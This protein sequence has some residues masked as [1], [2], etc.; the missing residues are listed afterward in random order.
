MDSGIFYSFLL[1]L[2]L[3]ANTLSALAGGGA[4]LVQLPALI[5][6]GLPFGIALATHKIATVALGVG[7]ALRY[8][9]EGLIDHKL[10]MVVLLFGLP[11]VVLGSVVI[12]NIN[13][14]LSTFTLGLLTLLLSLYSITNKQLGEKLSK[15]NTDTKGLIKGGLIIFV[16]GVANGSLSSGTGLFATLWFI[17]WFGLDYKRAV[18]LTML[19][20]GLFWNGTG[21]ITLSIIGEVRWDWLIPLIFGAV[22]GGYLGANIAVMKGNRF[23]KRCF[24]CL[25]CVVGVSLMTKVVLSI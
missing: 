23:I 22:A 16:I 12:L 14:L 18:A 10:V 17:Y 2:S 1:L 3:V 5:L 11:G 4:G 6:L 7:S 19:L 15:K 20:V 24:E 21:A 25:T 13:E 9:K 8:Q